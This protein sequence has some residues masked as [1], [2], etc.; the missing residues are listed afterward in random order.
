[1]IILNNIARDNL[2]MDVLNNAKNSAMDSYKTTKW[3]YHKILNLKHRLS[4]LERETYSLRNRVNEDELS[5]EKK[6]E[7][8]NTTS[9]DMVKTLQGIS[10]KNLNILKDHDSI[11]R[12]I[13]RGEDQSS[14]E[15]EQGINQKDKPLEEGV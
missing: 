8:F 14:K 6:L 3:L 1:M 12:L 2:E 5:T 10:E 9:L 11:K 15:K 13:H 7:A 4:V